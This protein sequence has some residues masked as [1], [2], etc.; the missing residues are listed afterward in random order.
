MAEMMSPD[1]LVR[2]MG[3]YLDEM[4][5]IIAAQGGTVD[6]FI[7]DAIMAFWG[8]PAESADHAARACETAVQCQRKLAD[9]RAT[10]STPWGKGL[11][12][13]TGIA[14]GSALVGNIG[15]PERFNYTV[16]G[17]TVNLASRLES[18]NKLYGTAILVSEATYRAAG[19]RV[20]GRPVDV[21]QV[22]GRQSGVKLYELLCL[23]TDEDREARDLAA[24]GEQG[25]GA[26][27][28][29]DFE[30][31]ARRFDAMLRLRPHDPAAAM[32]LD[33]CRE[34]IAAPPPADWTGVY[35]ATQK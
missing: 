25:L 32:L 31:A 26:Y 5:R 28:A 22:K 29:R 6:K 1:E 13:R 9:I 23:A 19:N 16:M 30:A 3:H 21:V 15:S 4:T 33:R 10:A 7:G 12:S 14:T 20:V 27:L 24:L 18:L 35:I 11:H 17:D 2:A 8:A 34:F